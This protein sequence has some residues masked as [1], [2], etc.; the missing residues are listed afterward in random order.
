M[1]DAPPRAFID[2]AACLAMEAAATV[3]SDGT[4]ACDRG[5]KSGH[6]RHIASVRD[7]VLASRDRKST[8]L[9][10]SH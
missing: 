4:G 6:Y 10:S 7:I 1:G 2:H 8:R 3:R 9:N 5:E